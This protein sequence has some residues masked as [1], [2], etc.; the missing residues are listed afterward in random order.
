MSDEIDTSLPDYVRPGAT[1]RLFWGEGNPNNGLIHIRAIVDGENVVYRKWS[2]RKGW[3]YVVEWSY[4]F[5]LLDEN[6]RVTVVKH[7]KP[8]AGE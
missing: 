1:L 7:G 4:W 6:G 2:R 5:R 3:R 8:E